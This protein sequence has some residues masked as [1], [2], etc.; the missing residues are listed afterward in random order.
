MVPIWWNCCITLVQKSEQSPLHL[1][2]LLC[3]QAQTAAYCLSLITQLKSI[4]ADALKGVKHLH[5]LRRQGCL[6]NNFIK[7]LHQARRNIRSSKQSLF[8][9]RR[10]LQSA[11][12]AGSWYG[13]SAARVTWNTRLWDSHVH[14][15]PKTPFFRTY[16]P[17]ALVCGCRSTPYRRLLRSS[18]RSRLR[19]V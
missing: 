13:T 12:L 1:I 16:S 4:T 7:L 8:S 11:P 9:S 17:D 15:S 3:S 18:I 5:K 6:S 10:Y 14:G 2:W 19:S